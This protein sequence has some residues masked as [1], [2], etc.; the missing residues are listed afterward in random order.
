MRPVSLRDVVDLQEHAKADRHEVIAPTHVFVKR[1]ELVGY[2]S[3]GVVPLMLPWF[4]TKRCKA[5]D[6]LY[7]INVM[8]NL[9]AELMPPRAKGIICV[10][11]MQGSPFE[12]FIGKLGYIN[13]GQATLALKKVS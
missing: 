2:A 13:A 9:A 11:V 4:D 8:E 7:F 6:S 5:A 1:G 10:P 3:V 12:P